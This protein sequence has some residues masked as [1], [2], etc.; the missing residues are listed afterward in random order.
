V[1]R[2]ESLKMGWCIRCHVQRKVSRDCTVCHY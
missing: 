1:Y 2:V